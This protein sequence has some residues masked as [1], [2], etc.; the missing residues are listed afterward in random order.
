MEYVIGGMVMLDDLDRL[1]M[2]VPAR[3]A[4]IHCRL[5]LA[6]RLHDFGLIPGTRVVI[7]YRSPDRGVIAL[8][9][10]GIVI[11][12]RRRDLKGVQVEWN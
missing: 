7:R 6:E 4:G 10:R 8:E 9:F 1:P 3:V 5:E 2:G 12:M 11:A